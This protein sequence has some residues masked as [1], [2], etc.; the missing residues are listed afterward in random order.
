MSAMSRRIDFEDDALVVRFEGLAA[1][2]TLTR[3]V[4][5]AY[6]AVGSVSIGLTD[7]PGLLAF[8]MG[9]SMPPFGITQ[10]G[11]FREHGRWS[12]FD[13]DD[14]ERAVVLDLTG[15]E[16]RRLVLTVDDPESFFQKLHERLPDRG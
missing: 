9:L 7:P 13:V 12:F 1:L 3:E 2:T 4:R 15:H 5:I 8:K 16:Y 10:R 11:R 6:T 14:R